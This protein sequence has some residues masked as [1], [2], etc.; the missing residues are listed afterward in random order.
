MSKKK[1]LAACMCVILAIAINALML[2]FVNLGNVESAVSEVKIEMTS[3]I[4]DAFRLFYSESDAFSE[5]KAGT[6][7]YNEPGSTVELSYRFN[8]D[9]GYIRFD[10]GSAPS[11]TTI[12]GIKLVNMWQELPVNLS[13]LDNA[14][15]KNDID[16]IE[17][18]DGKAIIKTSGNDPYIVFKIDNEQF[19][20]NTNVKMDKISVIVNVIFCII[21]DL[22]IL[23]IIKKI[24]K[25]GKLP[26]DL[27]KDRQL[28]FSLAK[29]DFKTRFAGSYLG[30]IWA[31]IQPIVTVMVYWFVF[32]VGL[33]SGNMSEYP[34]IIWLVAGLVPWFLFS[35]CLSGGTGAMIEYSYLVKKVV[36][37]IDI[38]PIVKILS[39]VLINMFFVAIAV[40]LCWAYGYTPNLYTLQLV[41]YFVCM[42]M[43]VVGIVYLTSAVVVFFRDLSQI[44]GIVLQVG[45][46]ATPIMWNAEATLPPIWNTVFK[47]NPMYYIVA[48]YRDALLSNVWFWD[49]MVWTI[50]F[51]IF[52][53]AMIIIGTSVF[54]KLKIHFADVL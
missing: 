32:Q 47:L 20:E 12:K 48:G 31:F 25:S 6:I 19:C 16:G 51:W 29:N 44:I 26:E 15:D 1:M 50:Y 35:D 13:A 3:D 5:N 7:L 17:I 52:T 10:F 21:I 34:F 11:I 54:K 43:L 46:W 30:I 22:L 2:K 23:L 27:A 41:Y 14:V 18:A 40:G 53:V 24:I 37:K 9:C 45:I 8:P 42:I 38:L 33:K 4:A 49:K 36:F 28:V 39:A